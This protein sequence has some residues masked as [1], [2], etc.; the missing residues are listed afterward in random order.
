MATQVV[1]E[2]ATAAK[3]TNGS[4]KTGDVLTIVGPATGETVGTVPVLSPA[5]VDAAV[6]RARTA[7]ASWASLSCADRA[8]ERGRFRRGL[9][10]AA[11]DLADLIH[12][13]N[14]KPRLDA[15]VEVYMAISHLDHAAKRAEKAMAPKKVSAGLMANYRAT[16]SYHPLG[17]VGVIGPWNY[18]IFTP[19]GSIAYALAAGNAVVFK[20]SELTPL[21]G[22]KLAEIAGQTIGIPSVLQVVTG[23]G[24]TGAALA[25]AAV[26]KIAFTGSA[27]TG[28][29]VMAA[30]AERLT[31]VLMELGG[32]DA[33]VVAEDADL[34]KAV[35]AAVFGAL[36][37]TGQACVSIERIYAAAP[38][39]DRFVDKVVTEVRALKV[40]GDDGH[41]GAITSP[42]QVKIIKD[43]L[44]DAV[45]KGA[46]VLTGG[47]DAISG[48]FV[49]PTVLVDV[50]DDM[51][52]MKEETFGPVVPIAKVASA[53]EG[54]RRANESR[55]GLG[56]AIW[57]KRAVRELADKIRAGMTS[58]N[59]VMAFAS[60]PN[61]P[62]G[63]IGESGFGRIHGD[64]GLREFTRVKSTAEEVFSL[65]VAFTS[66]KLPKNA[67]DQMRG[68]IRTLYGDGVVSR[69][70][71]LLRKLW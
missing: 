19:M 36:H 40:G 29:R 59:S 7:S 9:A 68:L 43:H 8:P 35:D 5:E 71:D 64:E 10:D 39:Y 13:E 20:P 1:S 49:Q 69:A 38:I 70:S 44:D 57:G 37:N 25:K 3:G 42:A 24:A 11:D 62:F 56:S 51:K 67:Y 32:K 46:R 26:D 4:S 34:D 17:V 31:P 60:I 22:V 52:I 53:E 18:P 27:A 21:I 33:M 30:A 45:A 65:P 6:A 2:T 63:G 54:V 28:K 61:L 55:Y 15:L 58:I 48:N 12:R 50:T 16:V 66:F 41:L 14:G 23:A 47:P